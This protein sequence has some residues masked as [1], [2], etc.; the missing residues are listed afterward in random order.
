MEPALAEPVRFLGP[1]PDMKQNGI[2]HSSHCRC[3][4]DIFMLGSVGHFQWNIKTRR[5]STWWG[6]TAVEVDASNWDFIQWA[7]TFVAASKQKVPRL[8]FINQPGRCSYCDQVSVNCLERAFED[9][10]G[11]RVRETCSSCEQAV[12][13]ERVPYAKR[14]KLLDVLYELYGG[15]CQLCGRKIPRVYATIE[16]IIPK[17]LERPEVAA[18]HIA[19]HWGADEA[20]RVR[21]VLPPI[22]ESVWN[23]SLSC[24][25]CNMIKRA[26]ILEPEVLV[27]L[28]VSARGNEQL[29]TSKLAT[30]AIA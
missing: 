8:V 10:M 30:P 22:V 25:T 4:W 7:Q 18:D 6:L 16:H 28:L 27:R 23:Y 19:Q 26:R 14:P 20:S 3:H 11:S 15:I 29:V 2:L 13:I 17:S 1:W 5:G 12:S 21:E 9:P 24:G